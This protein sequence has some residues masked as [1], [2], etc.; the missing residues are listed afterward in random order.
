MLTIL[1]ALRIELNLGIDS[2]I[3]LLFLFCLISFSCSENEKSEL[4]YDDF[5]DD[6]ISSEKQ[7]SDINF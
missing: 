1:I 6:N 5:L 2:I 3:H 4:S 7:Y